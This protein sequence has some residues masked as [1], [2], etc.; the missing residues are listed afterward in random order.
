M[1]FS[2]VQAEVA[3]SSDGDLVKSLVLSRTCPRRPRSLS[4]SRLRPTSLCATASDD[5]EGGENSALTKIS[6]NVEATES[7]LQ[8]RQRG[9]VRYRQ[10]DEVSL[11]HQRSASACAASTRVSPDPVLEA[12]KWGSHNQLLPCTLATVK[13][14]EAAVKKQVT[15]VPAKQNL[16]PRSA[17]ATNVVHLPSYQ[18]HLDSKQQRRRSR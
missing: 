10:P 18:H 5:D 9:R 8:S 16:P 2:A 3:T 12:V 11:Q 1:F 6:E 15:F 14:G 7:S 4:R 13:F 17:S